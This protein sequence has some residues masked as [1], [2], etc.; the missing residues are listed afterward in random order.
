MNAYKDTLNGNKKPGNHQIEALIFDLDG[1]ITQTRKT[2]KKAWKATFDNFFAEPGTGLLSQQ[3]MSEEDYQDYVDGKPRYVGVQSFL[4]SRSIKLPLGNPDDE[5]G[6]ETICAVGNLKNKLFNELL[7]SEGV[8]IYNDAIAKL[9]D[10][11]KQGIKTAIVSSSKNCQKIIIAAGIEDLFNTRVDGMVSVEIGLKGKPDPDIFT[12]AARRLNARPE[13]SVVFE[14]AI[15]GVQAGQK[16]YFGLVVGVNRFN[17]KQALLDNG[18]DITIDNFSELDFSDPEIQ[19]EYFSR[20]GKPIFPGNEDVFKLLREKR[21]AIFLDYDGTLSPIVPRPEDAIIPDEMKQTLQ[22][23]AGMF[24][25]AIVTGRDKDDVENLVGLN[26]LVYAGSHGYIISGPNGLFM[27]HEDSKNIIPKLDEIEDEIKKELT[28]RTEGTQLDRKRYAIG[29]HYRNARKEDEAV[30]HEIANAMINKYKG[31][32]IGAGKKILEI[33][34][35]LDWHKGKAVDWIL[36]ALKLSGQKDIIP[37]FIGDDM[38]DEDAFKTLQDKGIGI[39]VG[40]HGK[41]T[42]ATYALKN[43]FQVNEFF[44][45]LI[46]IYRN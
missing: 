9:R 43:V 3:A 23:L 8:E 34:P 6:Y 24:T 7:E 17:N 31:F 12:E 5:P 22:Q 26:E 16:G 42:A 18:A 2:H 28:E 39:L 36:K 15:A 27:E 20:Q 30:V 25:V 14:D 11:K 45:K 38:T 35:D 46:E 19:E 41:K 1:V 44:K 37:L 13:N 33:K 29:I 40:G 21:P 32:K 4:E 10:W